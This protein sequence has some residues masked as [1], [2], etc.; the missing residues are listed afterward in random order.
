MASLFYDTSMTKFYF[1]AADYFAV[2]E[3]KFKAA[4]MRLS[5]RAV[6]RETG[7]NHQ[8][9]KKLKDGK[10]ERLTSGIVESLHDYALASGVKVA[11]DKIVRIV[12]ESEAQ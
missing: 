2:L 7:V 4:G 3:Q 12:V 10:L 11:P 8:T 6:Q 5:M 9:L 1:S